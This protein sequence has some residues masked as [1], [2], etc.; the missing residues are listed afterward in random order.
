MAVQVTNCVLKGRKLVI[1][2]SSA[3]WASQL[4]FYSSA[5]LTRIN[6]QSAES[7]ELIQFKIFQPE[8]LLQDLKKPRKALLPSSSNI[9]LILKNITDSPDSK[10]KESLIKLN[11]KQKQLHTTGGRG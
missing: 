4:R 3:A 9:S 5:L 7:I 11:K 2:T 1:Y 10:L 8:G 6:S